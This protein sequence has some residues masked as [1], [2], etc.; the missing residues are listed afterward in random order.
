MRF[1][2]ILSGC[3]QFDGSETHE[4]ILTLLSLSQKDIAWDAFA[5]D[6]KQKKVINHVTNQPENESRNVLKE[7]ARLTRG[8]IKPITEAK[9]ENYDAIIFPGGF[10]AVTNLCDYAEKGIDFVFQADVKAFIDKAVLAKKPMGFICISPIMIPK[11]Y[12]GAKLTIG[13]DKKIAQQ[14]AEMGCEHV[15]CKANDIVIDQEYKL[16]S[17]PA[18]MVAK[19]IS[20]V[21]DG[22]YKLVKA[23]E[24][25]VTDTI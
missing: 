2:I 20:E 15:D 4:T 22:I 24:M 18:N 14:I 8:H 10:G 25:L 7:A 6:I 1:A 3:G 21:Y 5:P 16:V 17:T 23:V 11:I 9:I 13:H 12:K 19:N